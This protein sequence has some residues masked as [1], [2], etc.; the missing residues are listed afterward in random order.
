MENP[1]DRSRRHYCVF[2][3]AGGFCAVA[4]NDSGITRFQLPTRT[5]ETAER[6]MLRR[7]ESA[8]R[9]EPPTPVAD[10][11]AAAKRYFDGEP[12]DFFEVPLD[13]GDE[14]E[15]F[16]RIYALLRRIGWG[17]TTTYGMLAKDLGAGPE[18]ARDVGLAMARNPMP[19]RIPCHRVLAAG[20]KLGGFSAPGGSVTKRRLLALEG[21]RVPAATPAQQSL[22]F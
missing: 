12:V 2:E 6:L 16:A 21:V 13:L 20:G 11:I 17:R 8:E 9:G 22:G 3:T 1:T 5:F 19:L 10:A 18:V 14:N 7:L 15:L 4:W